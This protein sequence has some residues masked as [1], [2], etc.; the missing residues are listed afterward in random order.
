MHATPLSLFLVLFICLLSQGHGSDDVP[1]IQPD[2]IELDVRTASCLMDQIQEAK[3]ARGLLKVRDFKSRETFA[4]TFDLYLGEDEELSSLS[5]KAC[6]LDGVCV[7]MPL[8]D[9]NLL[10]FRHSIAS[11][12]ALSA[13]NKL[14]MV[15]EAL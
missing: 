9:E 1:Q 12:R 6:N 2:E 14:N 10:Q 3:E 15:L 7:D 5:V 13:L 11:K 4:V 8:S